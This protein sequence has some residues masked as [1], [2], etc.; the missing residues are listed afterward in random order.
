MPPIAVGDPGLACH[1]TGLNA[2]KAMKVGG[3]E[4]FGA[5]LGSFV[6]AELAKQQT[7]SQASFRLFHYRRREEEVD[8]VVELND[9]R[10]ILVEVKDALSLASSAWRSLDSLMA[11]LGDRVIASVVLYLGDDHQVMCRPH[12]TLV[13]APV[14]S[15]WD[16]GER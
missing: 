15:L 9:G 5:I 12:G 13:V 2:D 3:R 7:W 11:K 6:A 16:H 1:F 10:V 8:L 14:R 4:L